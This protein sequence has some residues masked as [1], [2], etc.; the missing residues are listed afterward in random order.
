MTYVAPW[1]YFLRSSIEYRCLACEMKDSANSG[2]ICLLATFWFNSN[3]ISFRPMIDAFS[4]CDNRSDVLL[5]SLCVDMFIV[6]T[7]ENPLLHRTIANFVEYFIGWI[8]LEILGIWTHWVSWSGCRA[9]RMWL[10]G[11]CGGYNANLSWPPSCYL[12]VRMWTPSSPIIMLGLIGQFSFNKIAGYLL[13]SRKY[14]L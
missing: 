8:R 7:P 5:K 4:C 11:L 12:D 13:S 2:D 14:W 1:V 6:S 3:R 10:Y 9:L